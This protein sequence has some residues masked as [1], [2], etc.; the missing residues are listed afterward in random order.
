MGAQ[1][2]HQTTAILVLMGPPVHKWCSNL[3]ADCWKTHQ[4][5]QQK[6]QLWGVLLTRPTTPL[7]GCTSSL[8]AMPF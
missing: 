3:G 5:M 7:A 2:H 4:Q 6:M 1:S 8:A